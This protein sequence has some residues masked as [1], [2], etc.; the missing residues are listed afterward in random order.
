VGRTP[1]TTVNNRPQRPQTS[2]N[3]TN[4]LTHYQPLSLS[5]FS[6]GEFVPKRLPLGVQILP[7]Q[8]E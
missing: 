1:Q 7:V 3:F 4:V 2:R 8:S 5:A 6:I